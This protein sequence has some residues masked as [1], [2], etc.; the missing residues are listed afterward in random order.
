MKR[1]T[2]VELGRFDQLPAAALVRVSVVA[3][4]FSVSDSTVW[5]WSRAGKLPH[6]TRLGGGVAL[7]NVGELRKTIGAALTDELEQAPQD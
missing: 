1:S 6:P 5:R 2:S 3:G 7:W 4:L